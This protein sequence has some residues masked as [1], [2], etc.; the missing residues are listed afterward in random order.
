MNMKIVTFL[1][2]KKNNPSVD[3]NEFLN[4]DEISLIMK[5]YNDEMSLKETNIKN[6]IE[7]MYWL[8]NHENLDY[9]EIS[10]YKENIKEV[11]ELHQIKE[12]DFLDKFIAFKKLIY[13]SFN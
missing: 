7:L 1:E 13:T 8:Y 10:L 11:C 4:N 6:A 12:T 3:Y 2:K 9:Y 5:W